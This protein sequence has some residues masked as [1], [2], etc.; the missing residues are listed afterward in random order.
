MGLVETDRRT[1]NDIVKLAAVISIVAGLL[2]V[3][4]SAAGSVPQA[5]IVLPVIVV[6]FTASWIQTGR[7][8][9]SSTPVKA[10]APRSAVLRT[11]SIHH[12]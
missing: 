5:A 8:N 1:W 3:A 7:A 6:A 12:S 9:R 4:A 11:G 10:V 2:A